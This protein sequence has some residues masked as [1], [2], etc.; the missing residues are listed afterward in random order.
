M[1]ADSLNPYIDR[2]DLLGQIFAEFTAID[3]NY[4]KSRSDLLSALDEPAKEVAARQQA[5]CSA[6]CM[7]Q[8]DELGALKTALSQL[9][10]KDSIRSVLEEHPE[11]RFNISP[12]LEAHYTDYLKQTQHP[13]T[14]YWGPWYRIGGRLLM[15]QDLSFTF[16]IINYRAGNVENWPPVIDSTL[17]IETLTYPAGWKPNNGR[18]YNNHNNYDVALIFALG[19]PHMNGN[20]KLRVRDRLQKMLNWCLST[21]MDANGFKSDGGSPADTYYYGVRFLDRLGLWDPTKCLVLLAS[22]STAYLVCF[23]LHRPPPTSPRAKFDSTGTTT[24]L[25]PTLDLQ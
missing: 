9:I 25:V 8:R 16:H 14:G 10:F 19:W 7:N 4:P 18:P 15:V 13:G 20:Q 6:A 5:G 12:E 1:S 11:L 3:S 17:E 21:A 23:W 24:A 22:S 2:D